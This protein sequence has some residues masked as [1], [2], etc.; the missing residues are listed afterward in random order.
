MAIA[1][2]RQKSP[3]TVTKQLAFKNLVRIARQ[4]FCGSGIT[5]CQA[6]Q[7]KIWHARQGTK[8]TFSFQL[9]CLAVKGAVSRCFS[10]TFDIAGLKPWL[11][12]IAHTRNAP[13]TSRE[14]YK[15]KYW[16]KGELQFSLGYFS[17]QNGKTWK[18]PPELFKF[19]AWVSVDSIVISHLFLTSLHWHCYF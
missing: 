6:Y 2:L 4:R 14:R 12:T 5:P 18:I 9:Q 19:R 13:W 3:G 16:R 17:S 1:C 10:A 15:V 8:E 11:S 7:G